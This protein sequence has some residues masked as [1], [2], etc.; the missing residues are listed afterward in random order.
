MKKIAILISSF[1]VFLACQQKENPVFFK[2]YNEKTALEKQQNHQNGRMKFKLFQSKFIDMNEVFKPFNDDLAKFSEEDY[3]A[4][5][6]LI[7]EQDIPTL[8][9][10]IKDG[11]LTYEKLTLF[12]LYRIRKFES[13]STLSLN[14]IIALNPDVVKQAKEKDK[15]AKNIA[16]F[17]VYGM[18]ILLKDNINTNNM[19]TT[20]GAV[21]LKDNQTKNDA[22]IVEKLKENGALILGKVNLS[23]WAYFFCSGCPLGY[24]AI[25]GQTLNPYGRA[26]FETGG[27]SAGSGV[28]VAANFAVAAIGTETSGSITSPSS[29][30]SVVGLKPTIGM[31]SRIGIVPI[32]STLDTPGPMTKNVIDNAILAQA[33]F[34]KDAKDAASYDVKKDDFNSEIISKGSLKGKRLGV[35]TSLL[36]DSI[37]TAT[38]EKLKKAGAELVEINPQQPFFNGFITLLNID[39][40]HDLPKYLTDNKIEAVSIKNVNDVILF[41]KKDSLLRAPYGQQLFEGIVKDTTTLAQLEVVKSNLKL[42]GE[43]YLKALKEQNLDAILS[44]NNYHSGIAAVSKHPT[45][46]VPMG[47]KKSGEPISLTFVGVPFSESNL[48]KI[49]FAFEQLTKARKMPKNYQ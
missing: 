34:G 31:F 4:L 28:T 29:L 16:D 46:T 42:D 25:G 48:L 1:F 21:A 13:D 44:I 2:K 15:N 38:I 22:F 8:Q 37:Y 49:G 10:T 35:L 19:P 12:Y 7:L 39:M 43:N 40:K 27:S 18:P 11:N 23:E 33:L 6:P 9:K 14:S 32:S 45:L 17:S 47:Y 3:Q 36:T 30:N 20:A 41:N 26:E 5:K 24:S